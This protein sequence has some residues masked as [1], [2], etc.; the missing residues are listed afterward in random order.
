MNEQI[1]NDIKKLDKACDNM[2]QACHDLSQTT[3][4]VASAALVTLEGIL[5]DLC[6]RV[7]ELRTIKR[8]VEEVRN[9]G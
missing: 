6:E 5:D 2:A 7:T 3:D 4:W 1:T 9:D 8:A